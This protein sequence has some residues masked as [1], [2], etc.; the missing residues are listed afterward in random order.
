MDLKKT[1]YS[2]EDTPLVS[3]VPLIFRY[4]SIVISTKACLPFLMM[5][6]GPLSAAL[7][8]RLGFLSNVLLEMV[9]VVMDAFLEAQL[10]YRMKP[11]LLESKQDDFRMGSYTHGRSPGAGS[12]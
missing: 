10:P 3:S 1:T 7:L 6:T 8:A 5:K 12:G 11:P 2:W 9:V 4:S